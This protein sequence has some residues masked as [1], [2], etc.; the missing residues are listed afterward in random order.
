MD[1]SPNQLTTQNTANLWRLLQGGELPCQGLKDWIPIQLS[2]TNPKPRDKQVPRCFL[3]SPILTGLGRV[4]K[5]LPYPTPGTP[6][7]KRASALGTPNS[8]FPPRFSSPGH[9]LIPTS[10]DSSPSVS[11]PS[12]WRSGLLESPVTVEW[13]EDR[14]SLASFEL[15]RVTPEPYFLFLK[16]E[17]KR[18]VEDRASLPPS[19]PPCAWSLSGHP[20]HTLTNWGEHSGPAK[21]GG[22]KEP[23]GEMGTQRRV[24]RR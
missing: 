11:H 14:F 5:S 24:P 15:F 17:K 16:F 13:A 6:P 7:G 22:V 23:R 3:P 10:L 9:P 19:A 1:K 20:G 21:A 4:P 12:A 8:V 2:L 18:G